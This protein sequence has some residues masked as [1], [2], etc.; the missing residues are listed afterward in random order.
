MR[1]GESGDGAASASERRALESCGGI[2]MV[3][4]P[5]ASF[6]TPDEDPAPV[7]RL[8]GDARTSQRNSRAG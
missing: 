5:G 1:H 3:T 4:I 8:I 6:L 7:A 2:T